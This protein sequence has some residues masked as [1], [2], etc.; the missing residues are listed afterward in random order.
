MKVQGIGC[1]C[2]SKI[3]DRLSRSRAPQTLN[4]EMLTLS[5]RE[6]CAARALKLAWLVISGASALFQGHTLL[7]DNLNQLPRPNLC[8]AHF[9]QH[10]ILRSNI[11]FLHCS[12]AIPDSYLKIRQQHLSA[13]APRTTRFVA[14][15]LMP[16]RGSCRLQINSSSASNKNPSS[17]LHSFT[18]V[19][20]SQTV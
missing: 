16:G 20:L 5:F 19:W 9:H 17:L 2:I 3:I 18:P 12:R 10:L 14:I 8:L 7:A 15:P 11:P 6:C 4:C 1:L 13:G